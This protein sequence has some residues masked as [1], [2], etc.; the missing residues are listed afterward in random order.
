MEGV[1]IGFCKGHALSDT[2]WL[3]RESC[4]E[5]FTKKIYRPEEI[6]S[7]IVKAYLFEAVE[8]DKL[9]AQHKRQKSMFKAE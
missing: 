9:F 1:Q 4:K 3:D 6:I 5:V 7:D 2:S 8:I